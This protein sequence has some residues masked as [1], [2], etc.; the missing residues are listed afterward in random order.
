MATAG[1]TTINKDSERTGPERR[2]VEWSGAEEGG[3]RRGVEWS[4]VE[5]S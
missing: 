4:E 2:G 1:E 3:E 5:Q